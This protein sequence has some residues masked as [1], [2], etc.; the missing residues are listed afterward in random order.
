LRL[1]ALGATA[2]GRRYF[3]CARLMRRLRNISIVLPA[4]AAAQLRRAD[5]EEV[6][7]AFM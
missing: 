3:L 7:E 6:A 4:P 1:N 5:I 2:C